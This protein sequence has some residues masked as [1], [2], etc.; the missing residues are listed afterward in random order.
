MHQYVYIYIYTYIFSGCVCTKNIFSYIW[1][2][3]NNFL[4]PIFRKSRSSTPRERFND[5]DVVKKKRLTPI[6]KERRPPFPVIVRIVEGKRY[7]PTNQRMIFRWSPFLGRV[8][9]T[10]GIE[11]MDVEPKIVGF[12]PKSSHFNR[13]FRYKPSILGYPY[14]W[15]HPL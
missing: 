1:F 3:T 7:S 13:V 6:G 5:Y 11:D 15:K 8:L 4:H 12:P 2:I 14:F 10:Q 9:S